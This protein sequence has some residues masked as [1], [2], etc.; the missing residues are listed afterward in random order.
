[1]NGIYISHRAVKARGGLFIGAIGN[2][3][4][5]SLENFVDYADFLVR[6]SLAEMGFQSAG[7]MD[8]L[9]Q[10][11]HLQQVLRCQRC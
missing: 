2:V 4:A 1:M 9:S 5:V 3:E 11:F 7:S 8:P 10:G 6:N